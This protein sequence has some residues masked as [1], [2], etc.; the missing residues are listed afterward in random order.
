[1]TATDKFWGYFLIFLAAPAGIIAYFQ[2]TEIAVVIAFIVAFAGIKIISKRK[3][4]CHAC[5]HIFK[6]N[7]I[8]FIQLHRRKLNCSRCD[9]PLRRNG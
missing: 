8:K 9:T 6:L 5:G 1:M 2:A 3:H 7:I 4:R